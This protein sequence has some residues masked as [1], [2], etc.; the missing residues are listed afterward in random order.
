[1]FVLL[2]AS[3]AA[4][5]G[6]SVSAPTSGPAVDPAG[7][8]PGGAGFELSLALDSG[9]Q[10][11]PVAAAVYFGAHGG[12]PGYRAA[13]DEWLTVPNPTD[14]DGNDGGGVTLRS[15]H[16]FLHVMQLADDTWAVDSGGHCMARH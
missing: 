3:C 7:C 6:G 4:S 14:S 8:T 5:A 2:S 16:V 1:V 12:T 15:G 13:A 11:T 10:P 9:G